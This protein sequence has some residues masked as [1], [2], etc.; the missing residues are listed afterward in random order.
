MKNRPYMDRYLMWARKYG[1]IFSTKNGQWEYVVIAD[2]DLAKE[3]SNKEEVSD[4]PPFFGIRFFQS[5]ENVG[6]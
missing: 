3:I 1:P 2:Y 6:K 4:R 5:Y